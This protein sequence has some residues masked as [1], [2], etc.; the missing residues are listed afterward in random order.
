[1]TEQA[2]LQLNLP[3]NY[4]SRSSLNRTPSG[5]RN[6]NWSCWPLREWFCKAESS[7]GMFVKVIVSI[8][9]AAINFS[10]SE[11]TY[12][13][14]KNSRTVWSVRSSYPRPT[15]GIS[16]DMTKLSRTLFDDRLL[17]T[18]WLALC[19][20]WIGHVAGYQLATARWIANHPSDH[21]RSQSF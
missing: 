3:Y 11:R 17:I 21:L 18:A 19:S 14:P 9:R 7:N 16:L 10:F 6:R 20:T 13:W 8:A 4:Y 5:I 2:S 1:M 12:V 15:P